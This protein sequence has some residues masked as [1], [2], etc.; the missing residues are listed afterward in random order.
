MAFTRRNFLFGTG[1]AVGYALT[2]GAG[3]FLLSERSAQ[4]ALS[5]TGYRAAVCILLLGGN[6][7]N[8]ML[9][10]LTG[11][12]WTNYKNVRPATA[13]GLGIYNGTT[14]VPAAGALLNPVGGVAGSYAVH[15]KLTG[16]ANLF[17][18]SKRLAFVSNVGTLMEKL[19]NVTDYNSAVKKKPDYLFSHQNQQAAWEAGM[20]TQ[21]ATMS[22]GWGGKIGRAHV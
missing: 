21:P 15:P 16:V 20:G 14:A 8:N 11:T 17:N 4:A 7:S 12:A 3:A 9:I 13:A 10:P 18:T 6:D 5:Y 1:A 19:T 22:S 2:G